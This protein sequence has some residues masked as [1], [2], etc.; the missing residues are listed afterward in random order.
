MECTTANDAVSAR[1]ATI[2]ELL[3]LRAKHASWTVR[4]RHGLRKKHRDTCSLNV[5]VAF[6][7]FG[8]NAQE[9]IRASC[10]RSLSHS[11]LLADATTNHSVVVCSSRPGMYVFVCVSV[12]QDDNFPTK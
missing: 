11:D 9:R 7:E 3:V 5:V 4:V 10:E 12:C 6:N 2:E 8:Y 1:S